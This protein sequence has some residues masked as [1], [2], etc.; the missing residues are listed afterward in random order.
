MKFRNSA[1]FTIVEVMIV[2]VVSSILFG[3]VFSFF[4]EYWQ[5][6]EKSQSDIDTFTS[7]LDASDYIREAVGTT[8]GLITQNSIADTNAVVPATVGSSYWKII[9]PIPSNIPVSSAADKPILYFKRY[10]QDSAKEFI[11]NGSS[12]YE[13]EH[14]IYL[15]RQGE[16]RVRDI[17]NP[18]AVGNALITTCPPSSASSSCPADKL[19]IGGLQSVDVRYFSRSGNLIDY[20]PSCD[21]DL[22]ICTP[23]DEYGCDTSSPGCVAGPDFPS[24]QVVEYT[25]NIAKTAATQSTQTTKSSTV[26]R[27][28]LRNT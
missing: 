10:A 12:P 8:S 13:N 25:L 28:A 4:W 19:L 7:R 6:A 21:P 9:H 22:G 20:T 1:G 17:A 15:S 26:I 3:L 27:V 23:D 5:Y 24:V 16:L 18:S 2:T 14:V 11:L